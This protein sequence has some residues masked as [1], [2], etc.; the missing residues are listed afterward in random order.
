MTTELSIQEETRQARVPVTV[1]RLKGDVDG[2]TYEQLQN[3]AAEA[4]RSGAR[5]LLLDLGGVDYMSS[6]GLR[7]L[8]TIFNLLRSEPSELDDQNMTRGIRDGTYKSAHLKL[9]KPSA[10]VLKVL[11]TSGMDM[12]LEIYTKESE[13][14]AAF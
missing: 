5:N 11:Q 7:A 12:F 6:A 4:H 8:N 2:K 1:F 3:L 14:L 13:A 10:N 9:L